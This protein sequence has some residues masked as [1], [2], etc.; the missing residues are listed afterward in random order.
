MLLFLRE[1]RRGVLVFLKDIW[2]EKVFNWN[3]QNPLE[4]LNK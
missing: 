4:I 2:E 3:I 1:E